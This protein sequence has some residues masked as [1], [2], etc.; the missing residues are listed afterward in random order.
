MKIVHSCPKLVKFLTINDSCNKFLKLF[1]IVQSQ[2]LLF[3][4]SNTCDNFLELP[5]LVS[6]FIIS[7]NCLQSTQFSHLAQLVKIVTFGQN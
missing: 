6:I 5:Q 2:L 1:T 4:I 3:K 7:E